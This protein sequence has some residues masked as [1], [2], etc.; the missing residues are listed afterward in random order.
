LLSAFILVESVIVRNCRRFFRIV[1]PSEPAVKGESRD[2][3]FLAGAADQRFF[4]PDCFE[5]DS[6]FPAGTN[7]TRSRVMMIGLLVL[8]TS[9]MIP[10]HLRQNSTSGILFVR[11]FTS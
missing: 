3:L 7:T 11:I 2:L 10:R 1:I 8:C 9:S 4:V 5:A 6:A